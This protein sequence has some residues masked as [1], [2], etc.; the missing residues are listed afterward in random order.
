MEQYIPTQFRALFFLIHL[1]FN[2]KLLLST[3][4]P[5]D[6]IYCC[7]NI[8]HPI[9]ENIRTTPIFISDDI[10]YFF[11]YVRCRAELFL[12]N[13]KTKTYLLTMIDCCLS[14]FWYKL[15]VKSNPIKISNV[16]DFDWML[17]YKFRNRFSDLMACCSLGLL[18]RHTFSRS[19]VKLREVKVALDTDLKS[20]ENLA[21]VH[22][23]LPM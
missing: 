4:I 5:W 21:H 17:N 8:H 1:V 6:A 2:V 14:M 3:T 10:H 9:G 19:R 20:R 12:L 11:L 23:I 16:H 7:D 18:C 22:M 13:E 15:P